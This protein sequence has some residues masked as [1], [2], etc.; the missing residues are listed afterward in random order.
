MKADRAISLPLS[1]SSSRDLGADESDGN[2]SHRSSL[3]SFSDWGSARKGL[4]ETQKTKKITLLVS[5]SHHFHSPLPTS[6]REKT[7]IL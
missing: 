3:A 6:L 4:R 7:K 1:R 5:V 2:V